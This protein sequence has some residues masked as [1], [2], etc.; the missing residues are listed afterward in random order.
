MTGGL[1]ALGGVILGSLLNIVVARFQQRHAVKE[2][3]RK[4]LLDI[5]SGFL[6]DLHALNRMSASTGHGIQSL[7]QREGATIKDLKS[8]VLAHADEAVAPTQGIDIAIMKFKILAPSLVAPA[9]ELRDTARRWGCDNTDFKVE[10]SR[11]T[12]AFID[13]ASELI[14]R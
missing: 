7:G 2:G 3:R 13:R 4:E 1:F 6:A 14:N 5:T 8:A 12:Q 10:E 11:R 9:E